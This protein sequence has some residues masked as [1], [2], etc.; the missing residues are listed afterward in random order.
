[1]PIR[2]VLVA[3]VVLG[4]CAFAAFAV[5]APVSAFDEIL[6]VLIGSGG[7]THTTAGQR[8]IA[9]VGVLLGALGL[10]VAAA[11]MR[12][13]V[14]SSPHRIWALLAPFA[15]LVAGN[16]LTFG[17][18]HGALRSVRVPWSV[19]AVVALVTCGACL[20]VLTERRRSVRASLP[21]GV[22]PALGVAY[23]CFSALWHCCAPL[24][25]E[26]GTPAHAV[27]VL[28]FAT[29]A[30]VLGAAGRVGAALRVGV[31]EVVG[32]LA[33]AVVY[34]W[35]TAGWFLQCLVGGA[36]AVGAVRVTGSGWAPV[37]FLGSAYLTHTTLPF[38]GVWGV[39]LACV[40][41]VLLLRAIRLRSP[42][43]S[44]A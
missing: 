39:G 7:A 34:P 15:I 21:L 43:P 11:R 18:R 1:M 9:F 4:A 27:G 20:A 26:V 30:L 19:W 24:W 14:L 8:A 31:G 6:H 41:A 36:F 37:L 5:F 16:A 2:L 22:G 35:H 25:S 32:A 44:P 38:L 3:L 10:S 13:T 23:G 29:L 40:L 33:F 17:W 42:K 28:W 12:A